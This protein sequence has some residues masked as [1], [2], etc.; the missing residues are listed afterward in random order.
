MH[1]SNNQILELIRAIDTTLTATAIFYN[2]GIRFT[3]VPL[4][5]KGEKY[6]YN[7]LSRWL[8]QVLNPFNYTSYEQNALNFNRNLLE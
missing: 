8:F 2:L 4:N 1:P 7:L 6:T 3:P 5:F